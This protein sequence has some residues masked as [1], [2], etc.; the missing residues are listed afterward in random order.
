VRLRLQGSTKSSA[1]FDALD[2]GSGTKRAVMPKKKVI[3]ARNLKDWPSL[4]LKSTTKNPFFF[5][6]IFVLP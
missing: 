6:D 2:Y 1:S 4:P 5:I 3:A